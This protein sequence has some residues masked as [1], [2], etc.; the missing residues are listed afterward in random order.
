MAHEPPLHGAVV[1][2]YQ[3]PW[4]TRPAP[5]CSMRTGTAAGVFMAAAGAAAVLAEAVVAAE[6]V[7]LVEDVVLVEVVVPVA[8]VLVE[9]VTSKASTQTQAPAEEA[10]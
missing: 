6:L 9:V 2:V 7:V 8:E 5:F 1:L 10:S 3:L 4:Y